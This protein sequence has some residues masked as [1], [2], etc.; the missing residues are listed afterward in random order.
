MI[1]NLNANTTHH[2]NIFAT[3]QINP[4]YPNNLPLS[5]VNPPYPN[6][7]AQPQISPQYSNNLPLSRVNP[8]YQNNLAQPL[9]H[10]VPSHIS[11]NKLSDKP[12]KYSML[13]NSNHVV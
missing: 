3:S 10:S 9:G 8:K 1:R 11:E 12:P 6:N 2:P 4:Q 13:F 7:L 5:R